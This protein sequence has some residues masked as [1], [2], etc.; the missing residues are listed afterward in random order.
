VK[1]V[2]SSKITVPIY[3]VEVVVFLQKWYLVVS[4]KTLVPIYQV[5][6]VVSS[7]NGTYLPNNTA[8]NIEDRKLHELNNFLLCN[9]LNAA[10]GSSAV[11]C[12][13][14]NALVFGGQ[15]TLAL[16]AIYV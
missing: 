8:Y 3:R 11:Q 1:V 6:V 7:R 14:L 9:V 2:V 16:A 15:P 10:C 5:E 13:I 12:D 4:S